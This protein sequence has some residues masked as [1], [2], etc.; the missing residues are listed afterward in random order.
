MEV[1]IKILKMKKIINF[2]F[3]LEIKKFQQLKA[4][5]TILK[6]RVLRTTSLIRNFQFNI[7]ELNQKS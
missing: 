7:A 3:V 5:N 6:D 2:E 1:N 4:S